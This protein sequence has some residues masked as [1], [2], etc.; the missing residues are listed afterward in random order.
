MDFDNPRGGF[1]GGIS[2]KI[3]SSED[4]DGAIK[5]F[6]MFHK[7]YTYPEGFVNNLKAALARGQNPEDYHVE[8]EVEYEK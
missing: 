6:N 3:M 7:Y 8:L 4:L 2:T 5:A 1:T